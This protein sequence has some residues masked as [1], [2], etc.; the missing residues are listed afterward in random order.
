MIVL[1]SHL[2]SFE[3]VLAGAKNTSDAHW[4]VSFVR[5]VNGVPQ[6]WASRE[7]VTNGSTD[8]TMLEA[9]NARDAFLI[10]SVYLSN[11]DAATI[12]PTFKVNNG[13]DRQVFK[14]AAVPV[15]GSVCMGQDG[16]WRTF[17]ASGALL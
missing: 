3:I 10:R 4:V 7:G 11:A 2:K 8:V 14:A 17:A 15:G 9:P 16:Q 6:R 5:V 1:D 12:T 13:A